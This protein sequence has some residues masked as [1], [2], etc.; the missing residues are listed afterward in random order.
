M[1]KIRY[2]FASLNLNS[3]FQKHWHKIGLKDLLT[4][5]CSF[6]YSFNLNTLINYDMRYRDKKGSSAKRNNLSKFT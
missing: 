4:S 6:C 5:E 2:I 1:K 3:Y